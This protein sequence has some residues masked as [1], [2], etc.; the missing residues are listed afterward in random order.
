MVWTP[1]KGRGK[2]ASQATD[3]SCMITPGR[4]ITLGCR[5]LCIPEICLFQ[6]LS[7]YPGV[8]REDET[9]E[10]DRWLLAALQSGP[11]RLSLSGRWL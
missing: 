6:F 5:D 1:R 8:E 3:A 9:Q 4:H 11:S 2:L 7:E 10:G